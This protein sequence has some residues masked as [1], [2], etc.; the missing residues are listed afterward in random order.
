[1]H[2]NI[3]STKITAIILCGSIFVIGLIT[4]FLATPKNGVVASKSELVPG[5]PLPTPDVAV[6]VASYISSESHNCYQY[7]VE[8]NSGT[9]IVG[10]DIG[11]NPDSDSTE[12]DSLPRGWTVDIV[13]GGVVGDMNVPSMVEAFSAEENNKFY[14][15]TSAFRANT[16]ESRGFSV[17]MTGAWDNTYKTAHWKAYFMDGTFVTGQLIDLGSM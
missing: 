4:V 9:P 11:I 3:S 15:S 6:K 12:L 10:V 1:M 13:E 8:N 16:S 14:V 7:T 2:S 17:C 5:V